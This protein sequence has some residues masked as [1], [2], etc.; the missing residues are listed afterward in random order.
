MSSD[1]VLSL[2]LRPKLLKDCVGQDDT[3]IVLENQ[4]VSGRIPHFYIIHGP[5]GAGKTTLARILAMALQ[6]NPQSDDPFAIPEEA[7]K[8]YKKYDIREINAANQNGVDDMRALVETMRYQP[9]SPSR[10]KVVILDEA[11]QLTNAAQNAL[12]TETED[13]ANHIYYIFCTSQLSKIIAALQ[14]RAY[15]IHPKSL[16][17]PDIQA[18]LERAA[19]V[20]ESEEELGPLLEALI[21]NSVSSPGLVLQA[22][23]KY[24][25][26]LPADQ[27]VFNT[28][29]S[30]LDT[31]AICRAIVAGSWKDCAGLL[32]PMTGSDVVMM[33]QCILGYLK[34]V[35]LK[36]VGQKSLSISNA[37]RVLADDTVDSVPRFLANVC[38]ACHH[39]SGTR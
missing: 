34:A 17:R 39:I 28:E 11:H 10:A 25:S 14:R 22:A 37:I 30:S 29:G 13:V 12:I 32:K 5:V 8:L 31:L 21:L 2:S 20:A 9:M 27:C 3:M 7:W 16:S 18:L 23:E 15:L 36:S 35:L 6:W 19:A 4:F 1:R 26:G 38:V 33:K 24:F